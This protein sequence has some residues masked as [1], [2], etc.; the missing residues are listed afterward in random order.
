MSYK[1]SMLSL[2]CEKNRVDAEILLSNL[3]DGGY[4]IVPDVLLCDIA[5]VNTCGFIDDAKRESIDEILNLIR[6]KKEKVIKHIVITGCLAERYQKEVAK[7]FPE[8][9]AVIGIGDNSNIKHVVDNVV[10]G[11][12]CESFPDKLNL[13]LNG[14]R[15]R[16]TPNYYAYL[17][18]ADGCDNRCAYCA[19]PLIRG[20]FRSRKIEDVL[21]EAKD[22]A[23]S[24]VKE[25]LVIAQDTTRYGE[26]LYNK[27]MLPTLLNELCKI[28]GLEWIRILYCYPDRITDELLDVMANQDKILN[29]IDIPLQHCSG[30]VL[31]NMNRRGD[32][33]SLSKLMQK[34]RNKLPDVTLRTTFICG[35]P[36]ESD[37]DFSELCEFCNE[38][39]FDRL[40]CFTYSKEEDTPAFYM[41]DQIE[42][43][44]KLRR[45]E[46]IMQQQ[47]LI[48][49]EK[50]ASKVGKIF[51]VLVEEYKED[52]DLFYGRSKADSPDVDGKVIFKSKNKNICC[53][54][55]V[56]VKITDFFEYDLI[57]VAVD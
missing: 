38:V 42:E 53:G 55:F 36:G 28:D 27:L 57:G 5:I 56:N 18:I 47:I 16:T 51:K 25:L 14:K 30:K 21:K 33:E 45:Q 46:I 39:K 29:Y 10:N 49:E 19:I 31:K 6:L 11:V 17:K 3:K 50:N 54:E 9:D 40:G 52:E 41:K 23:K 4:E 24:G 48:M 43:D 37:D 44:V 2:G 35:F 15:V 22:L 26:D 34:I 8:V 32:K 12:K 20:K 1:V 13:P 7:E